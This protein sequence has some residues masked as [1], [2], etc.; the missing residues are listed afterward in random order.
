MGRAQP[1]CPIVL[2]PIDHHFIHWT[3]IRGNTD[4]ILR[5]PHSQLRSCAPSQS[6]R[7]FMCVTHCLQLT[8]LP[9]DG[10]WPGSSHSGYSLNIAMHPLLPLASASEMLSITQH[11]H[12]LSIGL[13]LLFQMITSIGIGN[14][15]GNGSVNSYHQTDRLL[16]I[17]Q[18]WWSGPRRQW[19]SFSVKGRTYSFLITYTL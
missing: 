3:K 8:T 18:A 7:Q 14:L 9:W 10:S 5:N 16:F 1:Y 6:L 12:G 13:I 11:S 19:F 4:V 2:M 15:F 17:N